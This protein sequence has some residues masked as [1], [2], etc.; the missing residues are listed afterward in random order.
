MS[1]IKFMD[2]NIF[3]SA[4]VSLKPKRGRILA[5]LGGVG[6]GVLLLCGGGIGSLDS[7]AIDEANLRSSTCSND[8]WKGGRGT[9]SQGEGRSA[10]IDLGVPV[11]FVV[12]GGRT[13]AG[14]LDQG[15]L[16]CRRLSY[17][18]GGARLGPQSSGR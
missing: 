4:R 12:K 5:I 9:Q 7:R 3:W 16:S 6:C 17:G 8:P 1:I 2:R 13:R 11:L 10:R 15:N 14:D 18:G